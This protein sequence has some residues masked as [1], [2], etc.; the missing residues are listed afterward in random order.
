MA[1]LAP[2]SVVAGFRVEAVVGRGGMGVVYRATQLSLDRQVA[3]KAIAPELAGDVTFRERFKRES[4]LAASIEH[5]NVIPVYEAGEG[6]GLLYLTMR[7]V[8]GTDLRALIEEQGRL[9]PARAARLLAQVAA[10][11]AAAHRRDLMHRDVKPANVLIDREGEREH[12]YLTD[13]GIARHVAATSGLTQTGSVVGTLDYL[14]PE[15]MIDG[16]GD[17]RADVYALGCV[18]FQALTGS[19]PYPRDNEVAKMYAHL[20]APVPDARELDETIPGP[21]AELAMRTMAKEP[22]ARVHS[23]S[24]LAQYLLDAA[25]RAG[26]APPTVAAR[27][28]IPAPPDQPTD[29]VAE[30]PARPEPAPPTEPAPTRAAAEPTRFAPSETAATRAGPT[31]TA[32]TRGAPTETA[33]PRAAAGPTRPA[34]A[35]RSRGLLAAGAAGAVL[36]L[37]LAAVLLSGGSGGSGSGS[38]GERGAPERTTQGP[39]EPSSGAKLDPTPLKAI[40]LQPGADGVATGAGSVWIANRELDT[41][42]RVD[43]GSRQVEGDP[44]QVGREPDSLAAGLGAMWV[45]N[46]SDNSV[47]RLDLGSG[48]S[49]GTHPVGA[50]PEGILVARGSA[51][52][53]NGGD[54]TVTRLDSGGNETATTSVG[55]APVQL[56]ATSDSVWVTVS[57][58]NKIV[59]LGFEDG[60][61]TGREVAIDG[62]PRGI[63]F[64]PDRAELWV[65][66]SAANQL[67]VVDP[68]G[69]RVVKR[70]DVPDNPREVRFGLGAIWV[71]SATAQRVTAVDPATRKVA[72]SVPIKGT[73]YGLA[74]G[75]GL[76]WAA[77]ESDG[78][79][80][81]VR[82]R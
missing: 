46:T 57:K 13:F 35:G 33:A 14:A 80:L 16:G 29:P 4:R 44:I 7:Y 23:A 3:L 30:Q 81:P 36:A 68:A 61:P 56:A 24:E 43:A 73:T 22:D 76:A 8:E 34:R 51:W 6:E 37:G 9:E 27:P 26:S 38:D 2:G 59:E 42:T 70:V 17:A 63:A 41:V 78:L 50:A 31:E 71:T 74:V 47:T 67:A 66:A 69:A 53:A 64:E 21:L 54:G 28:P 72:G 5:P 40:P 75:E 19:V 1:E 79:L 58:E 52:I 12:A 77:S 55:T 48:K 18:L 65:S 10:A 60:R 45:T 39:R 15:R 25:D 82:P 62:T 32:A 11:L 20:N 49:L